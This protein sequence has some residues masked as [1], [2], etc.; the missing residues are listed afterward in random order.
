MVINQ[1]TYNSI[2]EASKRLEGK[3]VERQFY[4]LN[5]LMKN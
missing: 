1:V 3:I 5:T 2:F 4:N